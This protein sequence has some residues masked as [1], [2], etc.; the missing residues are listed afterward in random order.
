MSARA[1][2]LSGVLLVLFATSVARAESRFAISVGHNL[3]WDTDEPLRWAQQDAERMDAVFGQLGGVPEDRRLLLRGESVSNLKLGL[4]RMRGRIEESRRAGERTLLFF[5]YSGHGDEVALRLGGEALPLAEL[6]RL[7]SEVP[8]TVTV[9]V[10]D[11]CHSGALVRGRSKGLKSAPAFDVS[12]LRQVGPQGRVFIAS[13]G[14]HEVAQESD[15]LRGSFFT[16]HLISGLRGAADVDA[17]GRVSLTEAY[18]H[19]YHRTLAGSHASTAAVQHPELSSQLAGEGDLF[20][21]TLSRAHAQLELPPRVG[22]SVV[23]V[24]ERTLQVMAEVEPRGEAPVRV[25]L[26]AGRYRVQVR[27]GPEVLYGKVYLSWGDQ[28]RLKPEALEVRTLALHQRKGALLEAS[29][30]RLQVGLGAGRSSTQ[31][32]GW[33]PQVGVLFA[34]ESSGGQGLSFLGGLGLG[35]TRGATRAQRFEHVELG[36]WSGL[37]LAGAMGRVWMGAH[38]GVGVLGLAQRA[39]SPDAERRRT[40]GLPTQRTRMGAGAAAFAA[41]SAEVPVSARTGLFA[42][43]GGH[44]ALM[45]EDEKL[46]TQLAPQLMLGCTWGL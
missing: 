38:A 3:G 8:A 42:R 29:N 16:H 39:T 46:R 4:A 32:G 34:R 18:G 27:R 17:D 45:R 43:V 10:L 30:W 13:A 41:L 5:F 33:G 21:T 36:L 15:S 1:A 19:V 44:V 20:L 9:A 14:A 2:W 12:F 6:Q 22:D 26:P 37:G 7:L 35:A 28:Q 24:D 23:L 31:L 11:A 25:A 40:L